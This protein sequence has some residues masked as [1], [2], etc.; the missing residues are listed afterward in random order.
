ESDIDLPKV[1]CAKRHLMSLNKDCKVAAHF[2]S[3]MPN[4]VASFCNYRGEDVDIVL[5]CADNFAVS[6]IL[7]DYCHAKSLPLISASA[8]GFNGYIGGFCGGKPSLRSVF[9]ELPQRAQNCSTSGVMGPV[10]GAIGCIQAQ[11]ALNVLLNL[12]PS[13]LGQLLSM[14]LRDLRQSTFR[15]DDA[16][17]PPIQKRLN[18]IDLHDISEHDWLVDVRERKVSATHHENQKTRNVEYFSLEDFRTKR[19]QPLSKSTSA[20]A[21]ASCS[22]PITNDKEDDLPRAVIVCRTGLSAWRA[23]RILQDYWQGDICLIALGDDPL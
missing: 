11:L 13:P 22:Q 6:Y 15:F 5:D 7:S 9:P 2:T 8:L 20:S 10:V 19:P 12:Q 3:L 21:S 18:F 16:P 14:D 23:A 4:N 17:E 1:E